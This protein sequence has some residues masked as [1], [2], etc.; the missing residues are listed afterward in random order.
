MTQLTQVQT[1]TSLLFF[2][3][4]NKQTDH[5]HQRNTYKKF[6]T[7]VF[8]V[9]RRLGSDD[10]EELSGEIHGYVLVLRM[11]EEVQ[12]VSHVH[13]SLGTYADVPI[14]GQ[15]ALA[16]HARKVTHAHR[17]HVGFGLYHRES[18]TRRRVRDVIRFVAAVRRLLLQLLYSPDEIPIREPVGTPDG[19]PSY[20]Q[21]ADSA[22]K[23]A[24]VQ[25]GAVI[26]GV[27]GYKFLYR[28]QILVGSLLLGY[29]A[30]HGLFR[31]YEILFF[32]SSDKFCNKI[33]NS[34]NNKL[35]IFTEKFAS[36]LFTFQKHWKNCTVKYQLT[37]SMSDL[38]TNTKLSLI[39]SLRS[40][41]D[42]SS[43]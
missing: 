31:V 30:R 7:N 6:S 10:H 21:P 18:R 4:S 9:Y 19:G 16:V 22:R 24:R 40:P 20:S 38:H 32:Y 42:T 34:N 41:K 12:Q 1:T 3:P 15:Q 11:R 25:F 2:F 8:I 37:L 43:K 36:G 28:H 39:P 35:H 5:R 33:N 17:H 27:V 14:S 13:Q 26:Y 23:I 29:H